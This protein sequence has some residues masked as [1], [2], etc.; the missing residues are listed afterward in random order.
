MFNSYPADWGIDTITIEVFQRFVNQQ[1]VVDWKYEFPGASFVYLRRKTSGCGPCQYF[2]DIQ[3]E[4]I[5]KFYNS[6]L[7]AV[8]SVLWQLTKLGYL[9]VPRKCTEEDFKN[10]I[11]YRPDMICKFTRIDFFFDFEEYAVRQSTS[12]K[13]MNST[14]SKQLLWGHNKTKKNKSKIILYDHSLAL[15]EKRQVSFCE[16]QNITKPI[17]L[18]IRLQSWYCAYLSFANLN[19][20]FFQVFYNYLG[21][22]A[23]AYRDYGDSVGIIFSQTNAGFNAIRTFVDMK[24]IPRNCDLKKAEKSNRFSNFQDRIVCSRIY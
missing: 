11:I 20:D 12:N 6:I 17:R 13:Y 16:I 10:Y 1:K 7:Q 8:Q 2:V 23:K 15:R 9:W 5:S 3:F 21:I 19:G 22:L 14:Y 24:H 18:E 4:Y